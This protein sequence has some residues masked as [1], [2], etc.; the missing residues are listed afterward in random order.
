MR[1]SPDFNKQG[2]WPG[3]PNQWRE[4]T[5][6]DCTWY[7]T[8]FAFEAA[9]DPPYSVSPTLLRSRS[10]DTVGGTPISVALRDVA[11]QWP[12]GFGVHYIYA[13]FNKDD[14][15]RALLTGATVVAGGDYENLPLYYRR[16]TNNDTFAHAIAHRFLL[17]GN[18]T[19]M[20]DPLGGGPTRQPYDGEWIPF[21]ALYSY[22]GFTWRNGE[23]FWVG[24]VDNTRKEYD[25]KEL[26]L[27]ADAANKVVRVKRG[28]P[29]HERPTVVSPIARKIWSESATWDTV[30]RGPW[31]W[32]LIRWQ[33]DAG[34]WL[35]GWV[36]KSDILSF[37]AVERPDP[38][39]EPPTDTAELENQI[40]DLEA[41][42][43]EAS[44]LVLSAHRALNP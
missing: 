10:T 14:I 27:F 44:S 8:E 26:T 12:P 15:K 28:T 3:T 32:R 9:S 37:G 35:W 34:E 11:D 21:W 19:A 4:A 5:V 13:A 43:A 41:R 40:N 30:A 33:T 25:V 38:E 39:P 18:Q 20:Y 16:W 2:Y 36:A 17:E 29:V 23:F 31:G 6:D 24:I 7:A 22:S 1:D 42:T